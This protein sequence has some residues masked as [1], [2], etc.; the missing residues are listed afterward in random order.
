MLRAAHHGSAGR[1]DDV[2][3][4]RPGQPFVTAGG[5]QGAVISLLGGGGQGDVFEVT[6][7]GVRVALKWYHRTCVEADV[8]LRERLT[9]AIRRGAPTDSFLWPL[10]LVDAAGSGSFGYV[11]PLRPARFVGIRDLIAPPPRRIE[12][13]LAQRA[14]VCLHIANCFHELHASGFCYQDINFGNFFLD[15]KTAEVLICDNDNVAVDGAEASI[16]GTRKFMAPEVVRRETLPSSRTDLFSMAVLFFY[17]LLG[18][19]PLDGRREAETRVLDADAEMRLYG[20]EPCFLF[21]PDCDANGPVQGLH[22]AIVARW[23]SFGEPLRRLFVQS[24]TRGLLDPRARVLETEWRAALQAV[25]DARIAC[26][27]CGYEHVAKLG[28]G[29]TAAEARCRACDAELPAPLLLRIGRRAF[30][31]TPGRTLD[32]AAIG[33]G[34]GEGALLESHPSRADI[35]GLRNLSGRPWQVRLPDGSSHVVD[36]G[37]AVRAVPGMQLDFGGKSGVVLDRGGTA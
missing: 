32:Q 6:V 24:F 7:D 20:T 28:G 1:A 17:V 15:P 31:L 5:R 30:T 37:R 25:I 33:G 3:A 29:D 14:A 4:L 16:Y 18:W 34:S 11:M 10:D 26:G 13:T 27:S 21:D 8:T 35:L 23:E 36:G 9:R 19:H 2:R 22:D 12:L